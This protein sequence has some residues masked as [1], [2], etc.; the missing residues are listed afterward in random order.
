MLILPQPQYAPGRVIVANS[1]YHLCRRTH[2]SIGRVERC[3]T[4]S[5]NLLTAS[6][7]AGEAHNEEDGSSPRHHVRA[8]MQPQPAQSDVI[9]QLLEQC[10]HLLARTLREGKGRRCGQLA[11]ALPYCFVDV[12]RQHAAPPAGALCLL[13]TV[14]A[15]F[16]CSRIEMGAIPLIHSHAGELLA[17]GAKVGVVFRP[18]RETSGCVLLMNRREFRERWN[19]NECEVSYGAWTGERTAR[20]YDGRAILPI[21]LMLPGLPEKS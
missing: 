4:I 8:P 17:F 2:Q 21:R 18:V 19:F 5:R 10:F 16:R 11:G 12:N 14:A 9:L 1:T 3:V 20:T 7:N 13:R 15:T 6:R